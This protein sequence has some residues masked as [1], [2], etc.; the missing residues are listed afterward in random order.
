MDT[1]VFG[2]WF[3]WSC[4]LDKG[5]MLQIGEGLKANMLQSLH[6]SRNPCGDA[7]CVLLVRVTSLRRKPYRQFLS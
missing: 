6:T 7:C 3:V 1:R 5:W 2:P 4:V